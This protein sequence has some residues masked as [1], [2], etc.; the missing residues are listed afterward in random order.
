M[1]IKREINRP[2]G[3]IHHALNSS[4][5]RRLGPR[6]ESPL[7]ITTKVE[8]LCQYSNDQDEPLKVDASP[9]HCKARTVKLKMEEKMV[10]KKEEDHH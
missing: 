8:I 7:K 5:D 1:Q 10:H 3:L 4:R 9:P 6:F 2:S